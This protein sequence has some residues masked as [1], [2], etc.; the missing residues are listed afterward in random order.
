MYTVTSDHHFKAKIVCIIIK[1]CGSWCCQPHTTTK[2]FSSSWIFVADIKIVFSD[3][4]EIN[5]DLG[6]TLG[7]LSDSP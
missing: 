2:Q 3:N 1:Y 6:L 4:T 7:K 5:I